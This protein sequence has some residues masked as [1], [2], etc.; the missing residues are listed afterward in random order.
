MKQIRQTVKGNK[1]K[2]QIQR[3]FDIATRWRQSDNILDPQD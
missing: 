1:I 3:G 2:K